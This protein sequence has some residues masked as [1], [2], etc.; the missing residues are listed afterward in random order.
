MPLGCGGSG[1]GGDESLGLD[2]R[3]MNG[4]WGTDVSEALGGDMWPVRVG[5][6]G[7]KN[8]T[9]GFNAQGPW[10]A[11]CVRGDADFVGTGDG[12]T[13]QRFVVV[14]AEPDAEVTSAGGGDVLGRD[15]TAWKLT[16]HPPVSVQTALPCDCSY[17][18]VDG[19]DESIVLAAGVARAGATERDRKSV[20]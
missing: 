13:K 5:S 11:S 16:A 20:V 2:L 6:L 19:L 15:E 18:I 10:L 7:L 4:V 9:C 1:S 3:L 17:E 14:V 12:K 8:K